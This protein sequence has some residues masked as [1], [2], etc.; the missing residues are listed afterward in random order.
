MASSII[1]EAIAI[2]INKEYKKDE[3]LLRIGTVAPDS[4][5]NVPKESGIKDKYLSHFWNYQVK[6]GQANNYEEFYFKYYK[7]LDNPFYFGYLIH[8][9]VDQYWKTNIDPLYYTIE[10]DKLIY[11]LK[12]GTTKVD[13]DWFLYQDGVKVQKLLAKKYNIGK[14]PINKED[15]PNLQ[16][17][18]AEFNEKGLFGET[19]T[20]NYINE[21]LLPDDN[22][23]APTYYNMNDM[24]KHVD[25]TTEFVKKELKRLSNLHQEQDK[26]YRIAVDIDDTILCTKELEDKYWEIFIKDNP[27]VDPSKK[28]GWGDPDTERF[29]DTYRHEMSFGKIKEGAGKSIQ[30]L[31]DRGYIVDLLSARPINKYHALKEELVEYLSKNK[32]PYNYLILGFY[33]KSKF[34]KE[35]NYDLLIDDDLR[36]IKEAK[37]MGIDAILYGPY[38]SEYRGIQTENWKDIPDIIENNKVKL[39]K[40]ED[41]KENYKLLYKWCSNK[42]VYEWFEQKA[43]TYDEVVKKYQNKLAENIEDLYMITYNNIKIGFVQI[44]KYHNEKEIEKLHK[45]QNIYE[46]DLFIGEEE[47][48][49]KGIGTKA[50]NT[51]NDKIFNEYS[52]DCIVL[53]AFSNNKRAINCY[54]KSNFKKITE[55]I[56]EDTLSNKV[57]IVLLIKDKNKEEK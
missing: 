24:I 42:F 51:I 10:N 33:S 50:I 46:Y 13:N 32:L 2:K 22:M 7:N 41:T 45:Y 30:T 3:Q 4:W 5:R 54:L 36:N 15:L 14:L 37:E 28:N 17:D 29:W 19:G 48:L 49:S 57:K 40:F 34:L 12:D 11:K 35:H 20:L 1:H 18:L 21:T 56:D 43:L 25:A 44:Y 26:K 16:Y 53:R 38:N 47:Y 39:I 6:E 27:D 8:L 55:Y 9:I 31:I 23:E 52:A